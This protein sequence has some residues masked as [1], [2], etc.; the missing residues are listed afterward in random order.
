MNTRYLSGVLAFFLG[1]TIYWGVAA[2]LLSFGI[3][4]Q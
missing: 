1:F 4:L 2:T 3:H